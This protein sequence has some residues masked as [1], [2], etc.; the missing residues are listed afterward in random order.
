[1]TAESSTSPRIRR[2]KTEP[3]QTVQ[4]AVDVSSQ[5][6]HPPV[7]GIDLVTRQLISRARLR[8]GVVQDSQ[9][10]SHGEQFSVQTASLAT[11]DRLEEVVPRLP[12]DGS[13]QARRAALDLASAL[14]RPENVR[15]LLDDIEGNAER[16]GEI[17][18][19]SF[20]HTNYF[21]KIVLIDD[22]SAAYRLTVHLW[23]PPFTI[24]EVGDDHIHDHRCDFW[25]SVLFGVLNSEEFERSDDAPRFRE[26]IYRPARSEQG[27]KIN[28]YEPRD[29]VG[30]RRTRVVRHSQGDT[31]FLPHDRIHRIAITPHEPTATILLRGPHRRDS[32]SLFSNTRRYSNLALAPFS[33]SDL[34]DRLHFVRNHLP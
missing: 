10:L 15:R 14:G 20:R 26:V 30:L 32:T 22:E 8:S 23:R 21:D 29:S 13:T 28:E 24:E 7:R 9:A 5:E 16:L 18:S 4:P 33:V 3:R 17:A 31:Y 25:S 6:P 2:R 12:T 34:I 27:V 1:M 11:L 19:R